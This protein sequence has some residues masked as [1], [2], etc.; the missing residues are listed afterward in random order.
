M[1]I[2][3]MKMPTEVGFYWRLCHC[4]NLHHSELEMVIECVMQ[5]SMCLEVEMQGGCTAETGDLV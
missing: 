1:K 4:V 5:L 3:E 2:L